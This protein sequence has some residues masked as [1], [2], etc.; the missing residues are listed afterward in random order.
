M[1]DVTEEPSWRD[2]E[3]ERRL[4]EAH[5]RIVAMSDAELEA[6]LAPVRDLSP[7]EWKEDQLNAEFELARRLGVR[8]ETQA[9]IDRHPPRTVAISIRMPVE[10]LDRV[11]DEARRRATP[12]QRLIRDLVEAGLA[13]NAQPVARLEVSA[14]LLGRIATERWVMVEVRRAS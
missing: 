5:D 4:Q 10:L 1:G 7:A 2:A 12:Y 9:E 3:D 14:D 8:G 6:L 13:A 11:R